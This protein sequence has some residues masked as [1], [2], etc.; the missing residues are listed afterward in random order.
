[1]KNKK[2]S[3]RVFNKNKNINKVNNKKYFLYINKNHTIII[4]KEITK[5]IKMIHIIKILKKKN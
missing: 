3:R 2:K 4:N 5:Y 1:M